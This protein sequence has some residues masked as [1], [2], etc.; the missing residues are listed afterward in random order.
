MSDFG[1]VA[2]ASLWA[3]CSPQLG[4]PLFDEIIDVVHGSILYLWSHG[5]I[6]ETTYDAIHSDCKLDGSQESG[7]CERA[8][9]DTGTE[10]YNGTAI[11]PYDVL[12]DVCVTF[13]SAAETRRLKTHVRLPPFLLVLVFHLLNEDAHLSRTVEYILEKAHSN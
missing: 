8:L 12:A 10:A 6:S 3:L 5:L 4:N 11:S 1:I 7:G 2:F 13:S 9:N